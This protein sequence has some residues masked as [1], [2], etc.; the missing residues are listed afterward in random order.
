MTHIAGHD[1]SQ[2]LLLPQSL[3]EYVGQDNLSASSTPSSTNW[4]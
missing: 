3:D 2:I 4:T 1:R